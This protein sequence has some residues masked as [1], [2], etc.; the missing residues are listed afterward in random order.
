MSARH[1][2]RALVWA[3]LF[4]IILVVGKALLDL[5]VSNHEYAVADLALALFID[6]VGLEMVRPLIWYA[7]SYGC[8]M[9]G[10]ALAYVNVKEE[11]K[12]NVVFTALMLLP[13]VLFVMVMFYTTKRLPYPGY[14]LQF[15]E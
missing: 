5:A 7:L 6:A 13:V 2:P 8:L 3:F 9:I 15:N 1:G 11:E 4:L 14:A 12:I 10:F